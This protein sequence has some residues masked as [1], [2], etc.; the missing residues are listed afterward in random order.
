MMGTL[1]GR[2]GPK[3]PHLGPFVT[4]HRYK[5]RY[6]KA[7]SVLGAFE[8]TAGQF[9]VEGTATAY[10]S[11]VTAVQAVRNNS[12]VTLDFSIVKGGTGAKQ[13]VTVDVP[14]IALGDARLNVE[15][16]APITLPLETAAAADRV[17]NHTL[18]MVFWDFLPDAADV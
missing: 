2:T 1:Q 14:L 15:Q 3:R 5:S 18:L 13:G 16:D 8:V 12:D 17:F 6:N 11:N 4:R 10:F 7:I 9:N